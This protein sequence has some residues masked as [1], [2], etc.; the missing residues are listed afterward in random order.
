MDVRNLKNPKES[1]QSYH[2]SQS[3][4]WLIDESESL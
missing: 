1:A 4:K 3:K 2:I